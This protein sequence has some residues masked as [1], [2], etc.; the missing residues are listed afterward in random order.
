MLNTTHFLREDIDTWL[1]TLPIAGS[2]KHTYL[3]QTTR[4]YNLTQG[5]LDPL[6]VRTYLLDGMMEKRVYAR[7]YAVKSLLQWLAK[8][9]SLDWTI[10]QPMF[11][12]GNENIKYQVQDRKEM[13]TLEYGQVTDLIQKLK[14]KELRAI[15]STCFDT[16]GRVQAIIKLK[17]EGIFKFEGRYWVSIVEKGNKFIQRKITHETYRLL[18]TI[19]KT[20]KFDYPFLGITLEGKEQP[21]QDTIA[22]WYHHHLYILQTETQVLYGYPISFHWI[23]RAAANYWYKKFNNDIVAV[24]EFLGHQDAKI[25]S[26]Y[27]KLS[28][29]RVSEAMDKETR[30]W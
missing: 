3:I 14:S 20:S 30:R 19:T 15:I 23:R 12:K 5:A 9:G 24:K 8:Q 6:K 4:L 28:G 17:K 22:E 18:S 7:K 25:T 16:G 27:L 11:I 26:K 21:S 10:Y 2:T 13:E 29:Q 1:S